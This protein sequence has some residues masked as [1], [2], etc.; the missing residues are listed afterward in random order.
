M[1]LLRSGEAGSAA[2]ELAIS[3]ALLTRVSKGELPTHAA[4]LPAAR[5]G[6]VRQARPAQRRAIA[7]A[8]AGRPRAR[9]RARAAAPRRARR[10]LQRATRSGSTSCGRSTIPPPA[11]TT[12]SR[13]EGERLAGALRGLGV[14]ARVGEVPG[15]YCPGAYS[16]NARGRVK[17][18]GTAQRLVRGAALLGASVVVGDG[19]EHPRR[20]A[21]RLRRARVRVGR[22]HG[23]RARRGGP[24]HHA[25]RRRGGADRG[26][27][28]PRAGGPGRGRRSPWPT[29]SSRERRTLGAR[30]RGGFLRVVLRGGLELLRVLAAAL[31]RGSRRRPARPACRARAPPGRSPSRGRSRRRR[32]RPSS[33][34]RRASTGSACRRGSRPR[35]RRRRARA[36]S[37][38]ATLFARLA[39]CLTS[40]VS[41][42]APTMR[43]LTPTTRSRVRALTSVL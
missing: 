11:P 36:G 20:P 35:S 29:G 9:L 28:R 8:V 21:R 42:V 26:L 40:P 7:A 33:R 34:P 6:R 19:R 30:G 32:S 18:I 31:L 43:S 2:L 22:V 24:G 39:W 10:G 15:E 3:H 4:R 13:R 16:V 27:R 25:R 23:G 41:G 14:D 37:P 38:R 5:G 1:R 12:A 17:L